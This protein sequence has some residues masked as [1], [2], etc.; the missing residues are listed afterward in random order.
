[1]IRSYLQ[2][3]KGATLVLVALFMVVLLGFVGLVLDV[4]NLYMEKS[5]MQTA[6]DMAAL[7]GANQ[8]PDDGQATA[9]AEKIITANNEVHSLKSL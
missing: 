8:L 5:H 6:V 9:N 7:A 4:G 1:M 2:N 3:K